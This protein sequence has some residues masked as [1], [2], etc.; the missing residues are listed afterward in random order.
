MNNNPTLL[1]KNNIINHGIL[2]RIIQHIL[3][4]QLTTKSMLYTNNNIVDY[5]S[6]IINQIVI[7]T[8]NNIIIYDN[9]IQ[10]DNIDHIK[11]HI[12]QCLQP[13][14]Q[15]IN[16]QHIID[17]ININNN[18]NNKIIA[19][20]YLYT[21]NDDSYDNV[22]IDNNTENIIQQQQQDKDNIMLNHVFYN[23]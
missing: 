13:I 15:S 7:Y 21:N 11:L 19:N 8:L 2:K 22:K 16:I 9:N 5:I 10:Y 14:I 6:N 4:Q 12:Q 17:Q 23:E 20:Q 3:N 18:N 1:N